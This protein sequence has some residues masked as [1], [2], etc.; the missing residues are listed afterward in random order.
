MEADNSRRHAGGGYDE[1][2]RV[3]TPTRVKLFQSHLFI[4]FIGAIFGTATMAVILSRDNAAL[5]QHA[6]KVQRDSIAGWTASSPAE[7]RDSIVAREARRQGAPVGLMIA[8]G[9]VEDP[10]GDSAAR[11]PVGAVGIMQVMPAWQHSF[12]DDCGCLPLTDR[13]TNAC[14]GVHIYLRYRDSRSE[15][16]RVG[17]ECRSRWSPYH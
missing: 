4:W 5:T 15:E 14:R 13:R 3:V 9:R 17:K 6:L 8:I 1:A 2:P 12:E 7:Q 10:T 11:S 16:R